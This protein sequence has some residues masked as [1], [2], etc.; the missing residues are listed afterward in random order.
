MDCMSLIGNEPVELSPALACL[1]NEHI[2]LT[3]QMTD[4]YQLSV[5]IQQ[6]QMEGLAAS[7]RELYEKVTAFIKDLEP[8]SEKEETILFE[9]MAQYIGKENGP[10]AVMEYEHEQARI[11]LKNFMKK[12]ANRDSMSKEQIDESCEYAKNAYLVLRDHFMKEET[13]LFPMAE[14]LLSEG[15]KQRIAER[16][17]L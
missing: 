9:A 8:H 14:R 10:L 12:M 5:K 15:E 6:G 16:F 13:V 1:K 2:M 11:N 4:F 3:K 7:L 17:G